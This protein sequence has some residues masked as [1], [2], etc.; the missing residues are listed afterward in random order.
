LKIPAIKKEDRGDYHCTAENGV[1]RRISILVEFPPEVT[2]LETR[3]GQAINYDTYL[4]CRVKAYPTPS[5]SWIFN[6]VK[7]SNSQHYLYAFHH[8]YRWNNIECEFYFY[9]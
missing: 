5:I 2:G 4:A 8:C 3:V 9:F 6:G 1:R 7:L